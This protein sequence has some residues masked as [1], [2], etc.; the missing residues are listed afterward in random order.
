VNGSVAVV[1]IARG[2]HDHLRRQLCSV[3][4]GTARPDHVVVVAMGDRQLG[5]FLDSLGTQPAPSVVPLDTDGPLPLARARN[6]GASTALDLGAEVLVFLDVDCIAGPEL[7]AA[8]AQV[9]RRH[10][11]THLVRP[12]HLPRAGPWRAAALPRMA[13]RRS[14]PRS[15]SPLTRRAPA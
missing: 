9:V 11:E 15:P 12:G 4:D 8:Y 14:A 7:V 5:G 1:T 10:P 3:R 6:L 2:R 13:V